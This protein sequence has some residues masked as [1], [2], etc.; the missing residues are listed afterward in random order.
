MASRILY[1]DV[2][3]MFNSDDVN[4][5]GLLAAMTTATHGSAGKR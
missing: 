1:N 5:L 4:K 3:T 2:Y